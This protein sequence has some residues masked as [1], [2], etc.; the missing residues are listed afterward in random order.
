MSFCHDNQ[1]FPQLVICFSIFLVISAWGDSVQPSMTASS[2]LGPICARGETL[3]EAQLERRDT[4]GDTVWL[5]C[6]PSCPP[7]QGRGRTRDV[8]TQERHL[9]R[10]NVSSNT[11]VMITVSPASAAL[12]RVN[13]GACPWAIRVA[14]RSRGPHERPLARVVMSTGQGAVPSGWASNKQ[15]SS[16]RLNISVC[17]FYVWSAEL[18][19]GM[20]S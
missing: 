3:H 19:H 13:S 14:S 18:C 20:V 1:N 2:P 6:S 16:C 12:L 4:T 15:L 8:E 9:Q 17:V 11:Q 5:L 7:W 10:K